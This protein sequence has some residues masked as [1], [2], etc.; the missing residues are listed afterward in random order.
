MRCAK[1][2][3]WTTDVA[4]PKGREGPVSACFAARS[5]QA[6]ALLS[7]GSRRDYAQLITISGIR[8]V[9]FESSFSNGLDATISRR[10]LNRS[11][12]RATQVLMLGPGQHVLLAL[13]R[14]TPLPERRSVL[15]EQAPRASAALGQ[16]AWS[17]FTDARA[18]YISPSIKRCVVASVYTTVSFQ[19]TPAQGL[20]QMRRCIAHGNDRFHPA[21]KR[22]LRALAKRVFTDARLGVALGLIAGRDRHLSKIALVIPRSAPGH[23]NPRIRLGNANFGTVIAGRRTV[24]HL[25]ATGGK[26]P[27]RFYIHN[28][29]ELTAPP[30]LQLAPDGTLVIEPPAGVVTSVRVRVYVV[31]S[32]GAYSLDFAG[33]P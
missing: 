1:H 12:G 15:I 8:P 22:R 21:S 9:Y 17:F 31:D 18:T 19:R 23:L 24:E 27:Y 26:P 28:E 5:N 33:E 4:L 29:A 10:L 32:T 30:W 13:G 25:T 3:A 14:P 6:E 16:L 7:I 2:P 20:G 11:A